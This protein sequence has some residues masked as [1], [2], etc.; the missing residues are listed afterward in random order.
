MILIL[1][2][3]LNLGLTEHDVNK[4]FG[5]YFVKRWCKFKL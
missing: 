4:V 2:Y 3:F 1:V 5:A